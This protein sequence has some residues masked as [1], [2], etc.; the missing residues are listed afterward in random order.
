MICL[1]IEGTAHTFGIGIIDEKGKVLADERDV[2]KPK[3]GM[4]IVPKEAAEHHK[5]CKEKVFENALEKAGID[6]NEVDVIAYSAGPGLPLCLAVTSNFSK[7]LA[8]KYRKEIN[9]EGKGSNEAQ[10]VD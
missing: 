5:N 1:G 10:N 3:K 6:M 2:Y 7:E 4:G 9:F 8:K